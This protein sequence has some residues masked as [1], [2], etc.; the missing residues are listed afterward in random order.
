[1]RRALLNAP[2]RSRRT[3][4]NL[5]HLKEK[6]MRTW[7][8]RV[9]C[10]LGVTGGF[11]LLG[12][13]LASTASAED[14]GS[15]TNG[16]HAVVSGNQA[17]TGNLGSVGASGN[18]VT[19]LGDHNTNKGGST[20]GTSSSPDPADTTSGDHS[21]LGGNQASTGNVGSADAS[22]NQVTVLG[23]HNKVEPKSTGGT[24]SSDG[25]GDNRTTSGDDSALGGNQAGTGNVGSVDASDNQVTVIGDGNKAE[26]KGTGTAGDDG[27]ANTVAGTTDGTDGA[28][29]GNQ[30]GLG[31]VAPV[32]A[33][34]N[35][36]T[37]IGDGNKAEPKGTGT[38][39]DDG[40]ANTVAGTTDGTDGTGSGNQVGLGNVAPVDASGNQITVLGD[41][42]TNAGGTNPGTS[43]T[44]TGT[45]GGGTTSGTDGTGSG[46]QVGLGNVLPVDASGNQITVIGDGN[47]STGDSTATSGTGNTGNTETSVTD[48]TDGTGSGNQ[49]GLGNVAPVDASGNQ[50]TVI[51]DGNTSTGGTSTG[52]SN[53]GSSGTSTGTTD[54]TDSTLGGNQV[55]LGNVLP[56]DASG[57][58]ITV[59]GDGNTSTGD[60]AATSGTGNTGNTGTSAT[61]GT[62]STGSGNQIGL[63]NVAPVDTSGNQIT[64]IG[65]GNTNAGGGTTTGSDTG[66]GTTGGSTTSGTDGT[67]SGNQID[68]GGIIPIDTSGTQITVIGDGNTNGG[69]T[70]GGD[71]PGGDNPGSDNPGGDNPGGDNPGDGNPGDGN[72]GDG[73][74]TIVTAVDTTRTGSTG[75]ATV[76]SSTTGS[77]A[78]PTAGPTTGVLPQ[79]GAPASTAYLLLLALGMLIGG[80]SL[81]RRR[82]RRG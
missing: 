39:G 14:Q 5:T 25:S 24:D 29:S 9:L 32:D 75:A 35:Q 77:S 81:L 38:A 72:P 46:N 67:G 57:N 37:V 6:N 12:V 52:G 17:G 43:G 1:M 34:G 55:G 26:P 20:S 71:D 47:T 69:G 40:S 2:R 66:T 42:N 27:S 49:I 13:V 7:M 31:N 65:D 78:T 23:D 51:G 48:G 56:V 74:G 80:L 21:L 64:V 8:T 50:V 82:P 79:T 60:S 59:I 4:A 53:P 63:G 33:S 41:G 30:V 15:S 18:Q 45:T 61:D 11:L 22:D 36:V 28:G 19:V 73:S 58:Q 10:S 44:S 3:A 16:D 68:T 54:G 70:T 76:S 62:D